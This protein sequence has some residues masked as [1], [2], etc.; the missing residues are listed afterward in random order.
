MLVGGAAS[1]RSETATGLACSAQAPLGSGGEQLGEH[2]LPDVGGGASHP[3]ETGPLAG[4]S[5]GGDAA[6]ELVQEARCC[7]CWPLA[8]RAPALLRQPEAMKPL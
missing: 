8:D 7:V 6:V 4:V 1:D 2:L 5:L 3:L